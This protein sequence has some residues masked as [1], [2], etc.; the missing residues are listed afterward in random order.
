MNFCTT[1]QSIHVQSFCMEID[2]ATGPV[3]ERTIHE[4]GNKKRRRSC[5]QMTVL[6]GWYSTERLRS[7][8]SDFHFRYPVPDDLLSAH[9]HAIKE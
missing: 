1:S 2:M 8:V 4:I 3:K 9:L 7:T 6:H 5:G